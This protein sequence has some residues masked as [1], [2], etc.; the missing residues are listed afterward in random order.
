MSHTADYWIEQLHLEPHPEG[1]Y[2]RESYRSP[3]VIPASGLPNYFGSRNFSTAIYF[4]LKGNE[5]SALHK[6][7]SDEVWHF[8]DGCSLKIHVLLPEG[9][10]ITKMLGSDFEKGENLQ[11]VIPANHWFAAQPLDENNFTLAGCTL[12]PG[13]DFKDFELGSFA[14]LSAQFPLHKDFIRQFTRENT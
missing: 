3:N 11:L 10:L 5:F 9:T 8:Y 7:K 13:F 1:G 12:A 4:L 14:Q 6:L 2:F